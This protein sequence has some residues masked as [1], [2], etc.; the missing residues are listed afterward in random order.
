[1]HRGAYVALNPS[2]S[3]S[4]PPFKDS[5]TQLGWTWSSWRPYLWWHREQRLVECL[6]KA[7]GPQI[8]LLLWV[9]H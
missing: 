9:Q 4:A 5:S 2:T 6:W 1:M 3:H 8:A 7:N